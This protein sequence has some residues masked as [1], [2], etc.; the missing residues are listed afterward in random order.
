MNTSSKPA[1]D[2]DLAQQIFDRMIQLPGDKPGYRTA[3]AEGI[4]G[5]GTF[6]PFALTASGA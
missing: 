4:V 5:Q 3:H 1:G 2:K 6:T